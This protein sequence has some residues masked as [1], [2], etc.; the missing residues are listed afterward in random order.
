MNVPV[1]PNKSEADLRV[2]HQF[3]TSQC[4][5]R[6]VVKKKKRLRERLVYV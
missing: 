5:M 6:T 4:Y 3:R 1:I 2:I